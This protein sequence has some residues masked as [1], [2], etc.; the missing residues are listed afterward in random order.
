MAVRLV[1]KRLAELSIPVSSGGKAL[2]VDGAFGPATEAAVML[3]QAAAVD[4][5]GSTLDIDGTVGP[6][7]WAAL[8]SEKVA[9][10]KASG[11][12]LLDAMIA[13]AVSQVGVR[14]SPVGSNRGPEVDLYLRSVGL[15]PAGNFAWCAAFVF[16]LFKEASSST[17]I[18]NPVPKTAGVRDMWNKIGE[19]GLLRLT[20][21]Q[22]VLHPELVKPG[23]LFFL[24]FDG[25]LGH[26]G[27]VRSVQGVQLT[28]IEG[29]TTDKT[30]SR[31]GIGVFQRSARKIASVNLGFADVTRPFQ[32]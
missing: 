31:E 13:S 25:G 8:F 15:N 5:T 4:A 3:F 21:R 23:M 17:G 22:A 2:V 1:Q 7:T 10:A 20:P 29:N 11:N 26:M 28:T 16:W 30:G 12:A 19:K 14:E 9:T 32:G 6:M 24:G 27:I 18:A